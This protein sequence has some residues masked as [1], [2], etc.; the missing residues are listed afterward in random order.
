M[1]NREKLAKKGP[2]LSK[3]IL[4]LWRLQDL[5]SSEIE[6]IINTS[7]DLGI[8]TIDQADIYGNYKSQVYFGKLLQEKPS[9]RQKIQIVS[10]AGI[11]LGNSKYSQSGIGFYNTSKKHLIHS[12]NN[13]LL[14]L[15]T[16]CID[17]LLIHRPDPLMN[18]EEL[19]ETF[20]ELKK[21]GKVQHFGVSNFT[22]TQFDMLKKQMETP[23]VTNQIEFSPLYI[24]PLFDGTFDNCIKNDISP[25]IWSPMAGGNIFNDNS[26]K[27]TKIRTVLHEIAKETNSESIDQVILAWIM[28]HPSKPFTIIGTLKTERIKSAVKSL[29]IKLTKEQWFRI[30]IATQGQPVP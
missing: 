20:Y 22:P 15:N 16:D 11:V 13:T 17:L 25:M 10:K 1:I 26:E 12:V 5:K 9:I 23:L 24:N 19:D 14:D 21:T 29:S 30:L 28:M 6:H 2:E 7:L 18:P 27:T 4:G 8:T 3:L